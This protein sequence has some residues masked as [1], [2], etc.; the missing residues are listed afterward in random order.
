MPADD[1][2]K[3]TAPGRVKGFKITG[4][5]IEVDAKNGLALYHFPND[6]VL[7]DAWEVWLTPLDARSPREIGALARDNYRAFR[8][9]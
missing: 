9:S 5:L 7:G 4:E 1:F 2:P 8:E 6:A 3:R